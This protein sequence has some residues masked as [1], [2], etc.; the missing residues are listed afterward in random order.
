MA[1][2]FQY[3]TITDLEN[4]LLV[5]VDSSFESQVETWIGAAEQQ[6]NNYLGYVTASGLWNEQITGELNDARVDGDLN[7]VIHPRKRPINSLSSLQLWRGSD[8]ITLDLTDD[9]TNRYIIPVQANVIVYPN[10]ELTISG[11]SILIAGFSEIKFSR[12]YTK[13]N[14]IAGYTSI[15]KD[16]AY[17]TT[18]LASDVFMRHANKEGLV[19]LTQGRISKRWR[20]RS[21]GRSDLQIDAFRVLDHYR[22]ASGWF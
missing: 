6:V 12:W 11:N 9:S 21:D 15:P 1:S 2:Q 13:I 5:D 16:I 19:S 14:Y 4:L 3:A 18:L 7:L 8:S 17:A 20:E 22:V 10:D